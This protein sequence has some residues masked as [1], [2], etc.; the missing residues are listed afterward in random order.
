M[1]ARRVAGCVLVLLGLAALCPA[2]GLAQTPGPY[3]TI[4]EDGTI[5]N[6]PLDSVDNANLILNAIITGYQASAATLP[7]VISLWTTFPFNGNIFETRFLP[8]AND[9]EGIGLEA[10]Y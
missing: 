10:A 7:E 2:T 3:V 1:G 5:A 9:V 4:R 8:L 6:T